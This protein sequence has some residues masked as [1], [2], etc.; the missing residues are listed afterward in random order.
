ML[1][2]IM[3]GDG[4]KFNLIRSDAF[5]TE[6]HGQAHCEAELGCLYSLATRGED[7]SWAATTSTE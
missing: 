6:F 2:A 7:I 1:N 5:V 3:N 4:W